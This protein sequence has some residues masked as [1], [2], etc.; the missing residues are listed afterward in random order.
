[1]PRR[2]EFTIANSATTSDWVNVGNAAGP[3]MTKLGAL[4]TP[5]GTPSTTVSV[6]VRDANNSAAQYPVKK[7]DGT[8]F[9]ITVNGLGVYGADVLAGLSSL[10]EDRQWCLTLGTANSS[11][12]A[13][14]LFLEVS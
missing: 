11:G 10:I 6:T 2:A 3:L 12:A 1:M 13:I 8:A 9:S 14:K 7:T 4:Y 5:T